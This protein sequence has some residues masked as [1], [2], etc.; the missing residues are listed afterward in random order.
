MKIAM[1]AA[2][3][4]A[5][6]APAARGAEPAPAPPLSPDEARRAL[7]VLQDPAQREHAIATLRAIAQAAPAPPQAVAKATG[8]LGA[9]LVADLSA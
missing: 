6:L 8:G 1:V 9:E 2:L 3:V 4:L 5:L 7:E